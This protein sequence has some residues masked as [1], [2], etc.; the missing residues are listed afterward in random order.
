MVKSQEEASSVVQLALSKQR[1]GSA[2]GMQLQL[3][4]Y[5]AAMAPGQSVCDSASSAAANSV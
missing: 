2:Y 3:C 4:I 1:G 5:A